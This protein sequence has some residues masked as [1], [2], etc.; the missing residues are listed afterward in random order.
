MNYEI[1]R[2]RFVDLGIERSGEWDVSVSG[3]CRKRR[4]A[5][6]LAS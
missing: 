2:K 3:R 1:V 4:G 5:V 6:A